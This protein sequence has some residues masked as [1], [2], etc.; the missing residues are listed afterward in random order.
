MESVVDALARGRESFAQNAWADAHESLSAADRASGLSAEDLEL[1]ARSA[2]MLARDDDYIDVMERAH[3]AYRDSGRAVPAASCAFWIGDYLS[4]RG[5]T[6]PAAG[7]FARADRLIEDEGPDCV[8]RGY[9][10]IPVWLEQMDGGDH[11]SAYQTAAEAVEIGER[12]GDSDLVAIAVMEQG[13]AML[14]Q[15]RTDEGLRLVDET[16]VAVTSGD[17][18][19]IVAGLVYCNTIDF[20]RNAH[21]LRRAQEWTAVFTRW[22]EQQPEMVAHTGICL[23]HRAQLMTLGGAWPEALDELRRLGERPDAG[24]PNSRTLGEA[25]YQRGEVLRLQGGF[26]AAQAA[27][28]DASRLGLEPQPGLALLRLAQGD[29]EAAAATIRRAVSETTSP[30]QRATLLPAYVEIML[31]SGEIE[32]ARD[33]SRELKEIA[34]RQRTD[35]LDA[36]AAQAAGAVTLAEGEAQDALVA[37]RRA[38]RSWEELRAPYDAARARELVGLAC[39]SLGDE[40]SA[41][42]DFEAARDI[43][44]KLGAAPDLAR[45]DSLTGASEREDTHGLTDRELEVLRLAAAGKTNREIAATLSISEHTAA[46]H[47]QNIFAKLGVSSRAAAGAFAFEHGLV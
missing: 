43:Y 11:E 24:V 20:C 14:G 41:A 6:A 42:L 12:C 23:V 18:S 1:L 47:L 9:L 44:A 45:I 39:R 5:E 10:L 33:A 25:A 17:L 27:Y 7:W 19:P 30:L 34:E 26:D 2:Y 3:R 32:L 35:A 4:L 8:V 16:M 21:E 13:R 22:C 29:A 28:R 40:D 15:G 31:A 37:T 36:M 46:R 38:L